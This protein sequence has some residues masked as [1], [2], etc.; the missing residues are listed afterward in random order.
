MDRLHAV[1]GRRVALVGVSEGS[2][3]VDTYLASEPHP[4]LSAVV[5]VSPLV[6]AGRVSYPPPGA[7]GWGM[8]AGR[9]LATLSSWL[10]PISAWVD[11]SPEQ[12]FLR[13][14][15]DERS[16]FAAPPASSTRRGRPQL[17]ELAILPLADAVS[18][19]P[20]LPPGVTV[21]VVPAFH[22]GNLADPAVSRLIAA[23]LTGRPVSPDGAEMALDEAIA[24]ASS[25]WRVP[26]SPGR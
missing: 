16:V 25:A 6:D 17:P 4:P 18:G 8:I 1:S 9:G 22:G 12:P 26:S 14:L 2:A 23:E 5:L 7:S 3:V 11:L 15:L 13:S 20:D 10:G 24:A 21:V 19:A